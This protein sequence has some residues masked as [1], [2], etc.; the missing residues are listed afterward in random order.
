MKI[1]TGSIMVSHKCL[2]IGSRLTSH[3]THSHIK[4]IITSLAKT[5]KE[6]MSYLLKYES[7]RVHAMAL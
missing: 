7:F 2:S 6:N 1:Q 4:D 3:L 5:A